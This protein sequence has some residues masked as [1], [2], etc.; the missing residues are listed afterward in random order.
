MLTEQERT[1]V[2]LL[3]GLSVTISQNKIDAVY[4]MAHRPK[5]DFKQI[6]SDLLNCYLSIVP[7]EV[8][9]AGLPD[10]TKAPEFCT[11]NV[12]WYYYDGKH[13]GVVEI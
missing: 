12:L 13:E 1:E 9:L 2:S 11:D 10:K 4:K 8:Y 6:I 3:L 7:Q 5:P